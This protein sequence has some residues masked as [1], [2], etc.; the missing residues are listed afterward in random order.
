LDF[1]A[2]SNIWCI[3]VTASDPRGATSPPVI[4]A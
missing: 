1:L 4:M 2:Q 3:L